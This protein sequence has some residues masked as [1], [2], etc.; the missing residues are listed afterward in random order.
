[1]ALCSNGPEFKPPA[2][3]LDMSTSVQCWIFPIDLGLTR[4]NEVKIKNAN[5]LKFPANLLPT[6][7]MPFVCYD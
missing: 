1:M 5:L 3:E 6:K 2:F 7:N 4:P